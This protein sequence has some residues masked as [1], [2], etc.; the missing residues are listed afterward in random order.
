MWTEALGA[1]I[2]LVVA[3]ECPEGYRIVSKCSD[4]QNALI[5]AW[6]EGID[7]HLE[8]FTQSSCC[9]EHG[10]LFLRMHPTE[11]HILVRRLMTHEYGSEVLK[12]AAD[13]LASGICCTLE[14]EL[15]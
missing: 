5:E 1:Y 3:R 8:G 10:V 6:N 9:G 15:I 11:L 7:S 13:S 4:E 2:K 12:D 14:I